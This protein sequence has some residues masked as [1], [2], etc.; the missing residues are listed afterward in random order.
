MTVDLQS[1]LIVLQRYAS[2]DPTTLDSNHA[3]G[4]DP[5]VD[6]ILQRGDV[7]HRHHPGVMNVKRVKLPQ[8]LVDNIQL[9]IDSESVDNIQEYSEPTDRDRPRPTD[10]L[11]S[12]PPLSRQASK[13]VK[14]HGSKLLLLSLRAGSK[15]I[16]VVAKVFLW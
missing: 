11:R 10:P 1:F 6:A 7:K 2:S 13:F 9:M 8:R 16:F 3:Y 15:T 5:A 14:I 12:W 4:L